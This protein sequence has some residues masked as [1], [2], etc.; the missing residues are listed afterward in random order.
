MTAPRTL[1]RDT[2]L[3]PA[4]GVFNDALQLYDAGGLPKGASTGWAGLDALWT[5]GRGQWTVV[6]GAPGSGKSEFV[7][8]LV[9]NLC[10]A[11]DWDVCFYSPE[12][13]PV[14]T[15]LVKLAEKHVRKPF[16]RGPN[17]RM[18]RDEF[19]EAAVW[20]NER[21][22]WIDPKHKAPIDLLATALHHYRP[23]KQ[24]MVVLDPWNVLEHERGGMSETDYISYVLTEVT[25]FVRTTDAHVILVAHPTKLQRNKDGSRPIPTPWDISGSMAWYAKADACITVHRDQT[26]PHSQIV[27][28]HVQKVRFKHL[29]R[30]GMVE[31]RYDRITGRYFEAPHII[32]PMT[33]KPERY[34]A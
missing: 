12:N 10:S 17:E 20:I 16:G 33:G 21:V 23:D 9:V 3:V 34:A 25:K 30:V 2:G 13:W 14:S 27:E 19:A 24:L 7:D 8:A 4:I 11:G 5:V 1:G 22:F 32:D 29:G 18:T 26:D 6:T 31:V 28:I 15:H